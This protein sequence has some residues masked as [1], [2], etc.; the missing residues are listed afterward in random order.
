[1]GV[2]WLAICEGG[3]WYVNQPYIIEVRGSSSQSGESSQAVTF[4][5]GWKLGVGWMIVEGRRCCWL[6]GFEDFV[7]ITPRNLGKW[8]NFDKHIFQMGWFN[9]QLVLLLGKRLPKMKVRGRRIW[10]NYSDLTWPGPKWIQMVVYI[11]RE[12]SYFRE[13]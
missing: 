8:S 1:M 10:A 12:I 6:V 5:E 3:G 2:G 7:K 4:R 13:I 9:H 11:I